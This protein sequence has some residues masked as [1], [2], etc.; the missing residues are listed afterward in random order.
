MHT[1]LARALIGVCLLCAVACAPAFGETPGW[2]LN[3]EAVKETTALKSRIAQ[4]LKIEDTKLLGSA[5]AVEC[6]GSD[7][8]NVSTTGKGEITKFT[9]TECKPA[10]GGCT[11]GTVKV[12]ALHLPWKTQLE[13][14]GEAAFILDKMSGA[15]GAPGWVFECTIFGVK[16][17]DECTR[18]TTHLVDDASG[19]VDIMFEA[20]T[21]AETFNCSIG[22]SDQGLVSG[23]DLLEDPAGKEL[24]MGLACQPG[25]ACF[26]LK[27]PGGP[28]TKTGEKRTIEVVNVV[29]AGKPATL[30]AGAIR[31]GFFTVNDTELEVCRTLTYGLG[32]VCTF[33]VAYV[34]KTANTEPAAVLKI[35]ITLGREPNNELTNSG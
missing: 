20:E 5:V 31:E 30:T 11:A 8:G 19:G 14:P 22:G 2:E 21:E 10:T 13:G 1:K 7:E 6:K 15:S 18:E 4:T 33:E 3:K 24:T 25:I 28:M 23:Y 32:E 9:A 35:L 26:E 29:T 16:V 34:K 12:T 27:N 17:T